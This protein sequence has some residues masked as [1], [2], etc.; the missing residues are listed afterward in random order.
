MK[1]TVVAFLVFSACSCGDQTPEPRRR[2]IQYFEDPE[3]KICYAKIQSS[4][5]GGTVIS[6][7]TVPC[8]KVEH[9][10]GK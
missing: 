2:H 7:A 4:A 9:L 5:G 1:L 10:L 8:A 3:V 6:I